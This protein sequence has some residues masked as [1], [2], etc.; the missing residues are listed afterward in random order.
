MRNLLLV[1]FVMPAILFAEDGQNEW[2]DFILNSPKTASFTW[3][4]QESQTGQDNQLSPQVQPEGSK[5]VKKAFLLS[6]L[7]PGTGEIYGGSFLKGIAFIAIE[8][9]AWTMY[10]IYNQ[11]GKNIETEFH[12]YA[13]KHWIEDHYWDYISDHSGINRSDIEALRDWE[14]DHF[15]HGLHREKDQQYYEMVGKYDQFN[16]G[17]DDSDKGLLDEDWNTSMRSDNRMYYEDRRDAS[18]KA[19]KTAIYCTMGS[20]LIH[21][22]SAVDAAW[23]V[24]RHNKKL[25]TASLQIKPIQYGMEHVPALSLRIN[26]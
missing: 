5:S 26:W 25:A 8:V 23:T 18:N 22:L 7:V 11:E 9:G 1:L 21:A 10:A 12:N 16:Y 14:H 2:Q 19:F 20:L 6:A 13:D 3:A 24:S 17:W 4:Q 15:S